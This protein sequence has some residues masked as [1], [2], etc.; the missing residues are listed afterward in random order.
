MQQSVYM[1][2]PCEYG[3]CARYNIEEHNIVN[4]EACGCTMRSLLNEFGTQ[5]KLE[6][7]LVIND[8]QEVCVNPQQKVCA[9]KLIEGQPLNRKCKIKKIRSEV[10]AFNKIDINYNK[11]DSKSLMWNSI[12][13]FDKI[14]FR[15]NQPYYVANDT[16]EYI[17]YYD[18]WFNFTEKDEIKLSYEARI[19]DTSE[20]VSRTICNF[21]PVIIK[22]YIDYEIED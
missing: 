16:L 1:G 14:F 21:C 10:K 6:S 8:A 11:D 7:N 4:P 22:L 13:H 17:S 5:E 12:L 19:L 15:W 20:K 2:L 3:K 18:E 9:M